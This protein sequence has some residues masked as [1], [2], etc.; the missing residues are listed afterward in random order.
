MIE[1]YLTVA[2]KVSQLT[3][4]DSILIKLISKPINSPRE[5]VARD[6]HKVTAFPIR[7]VSDEIGISLAAIIGNILLFI[8]SNSNMHARSFYEAVHSLPWSFD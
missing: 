7:P 8:Q 1:L 2:Q 3:R 6:F 5:G 4:A